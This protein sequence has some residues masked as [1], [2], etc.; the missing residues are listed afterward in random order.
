MQKGDNIF[1]WQWPQFGKP[2]LQHIADEIDVGNKLLN[3]FDVETHVRAFPIALRI[4]DERIRKP[5]LNQLR[6]LKIDG[7][8]I[9]RLEMRLLRIIC[10]A[11][12]F[13]LLNDGNI[14]L[15]GI[16]LC[17]ASALRFK[18]QNIAGRKRLDDVVQGGVVVNEIKSRGTLHIRPPK[19]IDGKH[20]MV[21]SMHN[22][23]FRVHECPRQQVLQP[24]LF[25]K[26]PD[27]LRERL[28]PLSK[29]EQ[30]SPSFYL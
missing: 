19:L 24:G 11:V 13:H 28:F 5:G 14:D 22:A 16:I 9:A 8:V 18:I 29:T 12:I 4:R 15:R 2:R 20:G 26:S 23:R 10:T 1:C 7:E 17:G 27:F 25:G 30:N 21:F 6:R 3:D